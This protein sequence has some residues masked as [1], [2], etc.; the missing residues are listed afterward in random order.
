M[1]E[2]DAHLPLRN[3]DSKWMGIDN[4]DPLK[5]GMSLTRLRHD[6]MVTT[7]LKACHV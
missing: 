2:L 6:P 4:M 1:H 7:A 5:Q 3:A